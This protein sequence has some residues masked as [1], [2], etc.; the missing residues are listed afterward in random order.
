MVTKKIQAAFI[1][2][3]A[4]GF[5]LSGCGGNGQ[6]NESASSGASEG[7]TKSVKIRF[8]HTWGGTDGKTGVFK[9]KL[10]AF[11]AAHPEINLV[12]EFSPG[13]ELKTKLKVDMAS[14]NTPDVF[15]YWAGESYM[16]PLVDGDVALN[17]ADYF[18]ASQSVKKEQWSDGA[19]SDTAIDGEAYL[20]PIETSK[21]FLMYNKEIFDKYQLQPPTT[22]E[23][24][25]EVSKKLRENGIIPLSMGSKGSNPGHWFFSAIAT[26]FAGGVEDGEKLS[27]E[28][29]FDT[30]AFT[31]AA[32]II[33]EMKALK[34]FPDDT[35][36]SGD[37]APSVVPYNEGKAAMLFTLPWTLSM[38]NKDITAKSELIPMIRMDGAE[39]DP[40]TYTIGGYTMSLVINKKSFEDPDKKAAIVAFADS[41]LSDEMFAAFA[42]T[43]MMPA[44]TLEANLDTLDPFAAKV[45]EFTA[46]FNVLPFTKSKLPGAKSTEVFNRSMDELFAGVIKPEQFIA[47]VNEAVA[48]EKP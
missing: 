29:K 4:F 33:S 32:E 10:E 44:K 45:F 15:L 46:P 23:E 6:K 42:G 21:S 11:R 41:L 2:I 47:K 17:M 18:A 28:Y 19:W 14:G 37:W 20:I 30:E 38:L 24:F 31:K 40:A 3:F 9:E 12:D 7:S 5:I 22:Y 39:K 48:G 36:A 26:Q 27:T 25:K 35:V 8:A 43:G 13:D 1:L 16:R 34:A